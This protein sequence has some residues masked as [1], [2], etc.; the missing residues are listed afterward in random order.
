MGTQPR[1]HA[2]VERCN[3]ALS[4]LRTARL[5][6]DE[7][8]MRRRD[9]PLVVEGRGDPRSHHLIEPTVFHALAEVLAEIL[10]RHPR[11]SSA[12][13]LWNERDL[14]RTRTR[15][16]P[17]PSRVAV[18]EPRRD[19]RDVRMHV[20]E[21]IASRRDLPDERVRDIAPKL[22][23]QVQVQPAPAE[24]DLLAVAAQVAAVLHGE[25][26]EMDDRPAVLIPAPPRAHLIES[27]AEGIG[28]AARHPPAA[29]RPTVAAEPPAPTPEEGR[30]ALAR[31]PTLHDRAPPAA[32]FE[33][34]PE[35]PPQGRGPVR[36]V[37]RLRSSA[38]DAGQ[39][40]GARRPVLDVFGL[41]SDSQ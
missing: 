5:P 40:S 33:L 24:R 17:R 21:P 6:R 11:R 32:P 41:E 10:R 36:G 23:L 27:R 34:A 28:E 7:E 20:T 19:H 4:A 31:T 12:L 2:L 18:V 39:A 38:W 37:P 15:T 8:S 22:G 14:H 29:L 9:R 13:T 26:D 3:D 35:G 1:C 25:R 16:Q 30:L